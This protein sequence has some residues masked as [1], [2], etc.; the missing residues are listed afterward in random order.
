MAGLA[1]A[2]AGAGEPEAGFKRRFYKMKILLFG[3][4]LLIVFGMIVGLSVVPV[5]NG[6]VAKHEAITAKWAQVENQLQR[7]NDL[8]PNLVNSVKGYA[9]HERGVFEDVT[10]A[11]S[12]WAAANSRDE[13]VKA[14]SAIDSALSRL[15]AVAENYPVLKADGAFLRLMDELSGTE[16]RIAV[17]RMRYNDAVR[18]YNVSVRSFPGNFIA[19]KFGYK[20]ATEYF[21]AEDKAKVVPEVKF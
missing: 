18:E 10:L 5:Y 3:L 4:I 9:A 21:K 7:R 13:K 12:Q 19:R 11:R 16:N 14:A 15:I 8:I 17:E 2:L 6:I 20:V 1:E